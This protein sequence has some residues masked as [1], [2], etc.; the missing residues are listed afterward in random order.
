MPDDAVCM[1][2][3][4]IARATSTAGRRATVG[5]QRVAHDG[6]RGWPPQTR[7]SVRR[8]MRLPRNGMRPRS[9]PSPTFESM[10]GST[11]IDPSIAIATTMIEPVASPANSGSPAK[12]RPAMAAITVRPEIST[13]R[14]EV[15][16]ATFE[17]LF[18]APPGLAL[19]TLAPDVEQRVVHADGEADQQDDAARGARD[20]RSAG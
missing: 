17:R 13:V 3:A 16:A 11:V 5:D 20:R 18:L 6:A 2:S 19:F 14:P 7:D 8:C 15:A 10:A 12:Y 9:M 4:G 1:P